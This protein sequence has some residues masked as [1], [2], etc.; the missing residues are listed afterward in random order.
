MLRSRPSAKRPSSVIFLCGIDSQKA[1]NI[2]NAR[3][4]IDRNLAEKILKILPLKYPEQ[5]KLPFPMP[6]PEDVCIY[7]VV[8]VV[9]S[10]LD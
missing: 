1:H 3:E 6:G 10:V 4:A 5:P 9:I 7:E 2:A 8:P